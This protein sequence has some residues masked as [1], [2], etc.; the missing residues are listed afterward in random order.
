MGKEISRDQKFEPSP[1]TARGEH[2]RQDDYAAEQHRELQDEPP[3]ASEPRQHHRDDGYGEEKTPAC[4]KSGGVQ[5]DLAGY[6]D[7]DPPFAIARHGQRE[8]RSHERRN[9]RLSQCET[10]VHPSAS[11]ESIGKEKQLVG[12][13]APD[14]E[15]QRPDVPSSLQLSVAPQILYRQQADNSKPDARASNCEV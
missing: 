12:K 9:Y 15:T 14:G 6:M 7:I 13:E 10:G 8:Q 11:D 1:Q 4:Q 3:I 5:D 2:G